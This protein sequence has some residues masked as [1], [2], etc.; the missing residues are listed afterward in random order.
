MVRKTIKNLRGRKAKAGKLSLEAI[1]ARHFPF[2]HVAIS[3]QL[4]DWAPSL[5]TTMIERDSFLVNKEYS[6][7]QIASRR[8]N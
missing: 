5:E 6:R 4:G 7:I 3:L 8:V 2:G 1:I